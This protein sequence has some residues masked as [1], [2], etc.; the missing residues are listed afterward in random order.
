MTKFPPILLLAVGLWGCA[1]PVGIFGAPTT[2]T[3]VASP[4]THRCFATETTPAII[5]TTT[6]DILVSPAKIDSGGQVEQPAVFRTVSTQKITHERQAIRFETLCDSSLTADFIASLQRA[7]K[8]RGH[9]LGNINGTLDNPTRSAIQ[10]F[11]RENGFN[12]TTLSLQTAKILGLIANPPV[13]A[14]D[15]R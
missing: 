11:Q 12:S 3:A 4:D 7:L 5:E 9:Y 13:P 2:E 1:A 8:A 14:A 15:P 10:S 6:A